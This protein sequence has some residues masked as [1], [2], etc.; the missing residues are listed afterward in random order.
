[1]PAATALHTPRSPRSPKVV[2]ILVPGLE[3]A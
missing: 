2:P 3:F 1:M